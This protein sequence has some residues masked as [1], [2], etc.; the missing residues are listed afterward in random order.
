MEFT[1]RTTDLVV[2]YRNESYGKSEHNWIY[3]RIKKHGSAR[4]SKFLFVTENDIADDSLTD[5]PDGAIL[6]RVADADG[7]YWKFRRDVLGISFDLYI[8]QGR[9]L[10]RNMF[11][12][13]TNVLISH[14]LG[15]IVKGPVYIGGTHPDA[16][17]FNI[18]VNIIRKIPNATELSKYVRARLSAILCEHVDV[19]TSAVKTYQTYLNKKLSTDKSVTFGVLKTD[20]AAKLRF[21]YDR[22]SEMLASANG[23]SEEQWQIE[24]SPFILLLFP[25]YIAAV[26]KLAIKD[27]CEPPHDRQIDIALVDVDGNID[28]LEL[29]KPMDDSLMSSRTYRD[30]HV[31]LR[32][33]SGAIMQVEKYILYL[34]RQGVA[35]D[36]KMTD[37]VCQKHPQLLPPGLRLSVTNPKGLIIMGRTKGL[38]KAQQ[39]D[40]EIVKRKYK[41]LIDILSYDD[42][43]DRVKRLLWRYEPA[44]SSPTGP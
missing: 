6:V 33:L 9:K 13:A 36:K 26:G 28:I 32:E 30:N 44:V 35:G 22:L 4:I 8:E 2:E 16:V 5:D 10:K 25:K 29:K 43:L 39:A 21:I 12:A 38:S 40:F 7:G 15:E 24:L 19:D 18:F 1:P 27:I 20:E 31:P 14:R 11:V 23:Y 41:N 42:L 17:P 3:Q 34:Q 37:R